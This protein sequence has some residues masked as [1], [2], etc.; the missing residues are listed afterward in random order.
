MIKLD[1]KE[2]ERDGLDVTIKGPQRRLSF[3]KGLFGFLGKQTA[4][5]Y[6][7]I[8]A[9]DITEGLLPPE[10]LDWLWNNCF[11]SWDVIEITWYN[12]ADEYHLRW[13]VRFDSPKN[14]KAF[15]DF[16]MEIAK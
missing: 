12:D 1:R 8:D 2:I 13:I 9:S 3:F 16:C 10:A 4:V 15:E 14:A 7:E 5:T 11:N 6:G